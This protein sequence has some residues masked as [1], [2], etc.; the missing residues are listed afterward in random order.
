MTAEQRETLL[1]LAHAAI[2]HAY[3]PFSKFHVGAAVLTESDHFYSGSNIEN[4]S[5]GLSMCAERVAVFSAV[6]AEGAGMRLKAVAVAS[7]R[8]ESCAPCGACR[9]VI[10]EFGAGA[11][12]YFQEN[13]TFIEK[14]VVTLLPLAFV[15]RR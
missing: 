11:A 6:A 1:G 15:Q 7:D 10:V 12:I 8:Q 3:A 5:Y 2:E 9:Q 14:N 13:G 4:S